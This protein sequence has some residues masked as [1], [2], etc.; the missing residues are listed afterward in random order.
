VTQSLLETHSTRL[1]CHEEALSSP[2]QEEL[3]LQDYRTLVATLAHDLKNPLT[4]IRGRSQLLQRSLTESE[5]LDRRQLVEGLAQ[6]EAATRHMGFLL[7]ELVDLS[8]AHGS[9]L[10][11][12]RQPVDI[13][14]LARYLAEQYEQASDRHRIRVETPQREIV[15]QFDPIRLERVISNLLSNAV[16][17]SPDGGDVVIS[18]WEEVDWPGHPTWVALRVRDRGIGIPA[19]DLPHVFDHLYRARNAVGRVSGTGLGLA[20]VRQMVGEHGGTINM[21]SEH[22]RGSTATVRLP[23]DPMPQARR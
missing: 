15:G 5:P 20:A 21:E 18:V 23:L 9:R 4:R 7:D 14:A 10:Q 17:Y 13:V 22:G 11:M 2:A 3:S 16:K 8:A 19:E 6:I 12:A 1:E